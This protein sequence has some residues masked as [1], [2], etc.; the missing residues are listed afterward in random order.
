MKTITFVTGNETKLRHAREAMRGF[1]VDIVGKKLDI[2]EPREEDPEIVVR[3]KALQAAKIV[4]LPLMVEDS[5][6]FIRALGGFPKNFVH[7]AIESIGIEGIMKLM[8]EIKDRHAEF[9][10]SLAY[11]EPGMADPIIFSYVDG[12][13]T[14]ADKIW[15]P[16]FGDTDDFNKILIPPGETKPLS[17]FSPEWLAER[18]TKANEDTIH[19]RKLAKWLSSRP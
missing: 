19:Y 8:V 13:Y 2:L 4:N 16:E 17:S 15:E 7:F 1:D 14:I 3:E 11:I 5:G 12:S 18:D 9:R 6:I 10:Q